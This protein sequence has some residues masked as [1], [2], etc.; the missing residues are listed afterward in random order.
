MSRNTE[1]NDADIDIGGTDTVFTAA[2]RQLSSGAARSSSNAV[3]QSG[4]P[5]LSTP[6]ASS[7]GGNR[8]TPQSEETRGDGEQDNLWLFAS[9]SCSC[10]ISISIFVD[11]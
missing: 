7:T 5:L 2:L 6:S 11:S 9:A 3:V 8:P 10:N 1:L 4:N